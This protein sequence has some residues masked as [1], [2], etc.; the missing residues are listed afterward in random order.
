LNNNDNNKSLVENSINQL[1]P[2]PCIVVHS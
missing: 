1:L 2:P